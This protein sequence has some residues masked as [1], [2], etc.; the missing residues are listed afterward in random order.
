MRK[1]CIVLITL[2][3]LTLV[4]VCSAANWQPITI[5][6]DN[7]DQ[8]TDYFNVPTNEWR[9]IWTI[10][11]DDPNSGFG[12]FYAFVYPKGENV[13]YVASFD[14]DSSHTSGMTYIHEGSQEY[15]LKVGAS[16]LQSYTITIEYDT[17]AIPEYSTITVVIALALASISV[18]AIRN[19]VKN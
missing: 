4:G 17:T 8:N 5:I 7:T 16:N 14:G 11:P 3:I 19:K 12:A 15:Y 1:L 9:I 2:S 13:L 6:T 10:T 18:I